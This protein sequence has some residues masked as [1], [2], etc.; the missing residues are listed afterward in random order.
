[1]ALSIFRFHKM[2]QSIDSSRKIRILSI[3][4]WPYLLTPFRESLFKVPIFFRG[5][6]TVI[7]P[8]SHQKQ[9]L[10]TTRSNKYKR[11][12]VK[13]FSE[14]DTCHMSNGNNFKVLTI[15]SQCIWNCDW[16]W[17]SRYRSIFYWIQ[18]IAAVD[19]LF[20]SVL[21]E[22]NSSVCSNTTKRIW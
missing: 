5:S 15:V 11:C 7:R 3:D 10:R 6:Q 9:Q 2:K 4:L 8:K 1:M 16:M 20:E 14:Y 12:I 19:R 17:F 13:C 22:L 18:W 21:C